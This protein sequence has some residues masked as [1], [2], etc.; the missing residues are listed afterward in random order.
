MPQLPFPNRYFKIAGE[1][2]NEYPDSDP[3]DDMRKKFQKC[4]DERYKTAELDSEFKLQ[5]YHIF[6]DCYKEAVV[7]IHKSMETGSMALQL[8]KI[9][10]C[11]DLITY[12]TYWLS[13]IYNRKL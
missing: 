7:D 13:A 12:L 6:H 5:T 1:A 4:A 9:Y 11:Q 3:T 10:V 8:F 2:K